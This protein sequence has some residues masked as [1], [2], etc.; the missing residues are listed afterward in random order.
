MRQVLNPKWKDRISELINIGHID[1]TNSYN[2]AI[3]WIITELTTRGIPFK[4]FNL[5]A[6]VKRITTE[7]DI[8]PCC[9]RRL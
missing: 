5:G 3:Q 7:T 6:G 1:E 2:I 9:K 4:L 8:C